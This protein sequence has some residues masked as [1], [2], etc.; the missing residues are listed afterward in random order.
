MASLGILTCQSAERLPAS[1]LLSKSHSSWW[2]VPC[3]L[4]SAHG[5]GSTQVAAIPK[6]SRRSTLGPWC[7][8]SL[9]ASCTATRCRR[10]DTSFTSIRHRP[11]PGTSNASPRCWL[12]TV[13][14]N[15][16]AISAAMGNAVAKEE[17]S[18]SRPVGCPT[19]PLYYRRFQGVARAEQ[20]C[21]PKPASATWNARVKLL[22]TQPY[23]Q[24]SCAKR[25]SE[26]SADNSSATG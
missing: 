6:P 24:Q 8:C 21:A 1:S 25:S 9:C 2:G 26:A 15:V 17:Q 4:P 14:T 22:V 10:T 19:V 16:L 20:A 5:N 12:W 11:A 13:W 7:T 23:T 3:A 18:R